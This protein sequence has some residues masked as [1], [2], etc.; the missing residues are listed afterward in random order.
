MMQETSRHHVASL[1]AYFEL[2]QQVPDQSE[3]ARGRKLWFRGHPHAGWELTPSVLRES[4]Q[5]AVLPR[6]RVA[7]LDEDR[8]LAAEIELNCQ[9][10]RQSAALVPPG[11]E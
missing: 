6:Q 8:L 5:Q 10:R 4:F 9:F 11:S 7:A 1:A 2:L 3:T